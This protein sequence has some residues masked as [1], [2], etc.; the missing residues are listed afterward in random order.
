MRYVPIK[1]VE[2]QD[3]QCVHRIRERLISE[4]T[5]LI[6]Q[7][8][9]LLAEYGVV[10]EKGVSKVRKALPRILEDGEN[11]LTGVT[12]ELCYEL[13][14]ELIKLE[15]R[16]ELYEKK[17]DQIFKNN[18]LCQ[19]FAEIEGVGPI[20]ATILVTM[21]SRPE[22]FENGRHF[23]AYL[24]LVPKQYSSGGRQ[25]LQGISKRGDT[26]TRGLLIH[27]GRAVV[28]RVDKKTDHR[29]VWLKGLK[30]RR[31]YNRAS[32]ALANKNAR[33]MWSIAAHNTA[34]QKAM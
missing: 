26:Y 29:S 24:G 22:M 18:P 3:I 6:N 27:G 7:T 12:R 31:G 21:L 9:G 4:R 8:R 11:E 25:Q 23:A 17:I 19:K 15:E 5:A 13:Y 20:T 28:R 32:V 14:E 1:K 16:I 2:D 33:I 30:E 34:Y 10:I